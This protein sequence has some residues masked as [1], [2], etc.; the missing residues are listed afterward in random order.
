MLL[1]SD[2]SSSRLV[3]LLGAWSLGPVPQPASLDFAEHLALWVGA[4]DAIRLQS[5]LQSLPAAAASPAPP[6]PARRSATAQ[7][8]Q[9]QLQRV[10]AALAHAISLDPLQDAA[11]PA[12][13]G[14]APFLRRHAELQRHMEQMLLPLREQLRQALAQ[15]SPRLAQLAA[16]DALWQD[17]LAPREQQLLAGLP[18]LLMQR[19]RRLQQAQPAPGPQADL[20]LDE[21]PAASPLSQFLADW[22]QAL[23]AELDLR[24]EPA[25]GLCAALNQELHGLSP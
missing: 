21:A 4:F 20:G 16:L 12:Q 11:D 15:A 8:L 18:A 23:L 2:F 24:L 13:P 5:A 7:D 25:R 3:R 6:R 9:A 22:R 1:R 19:F 10:R 14:E 17:L